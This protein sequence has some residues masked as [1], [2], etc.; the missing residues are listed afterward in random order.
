MG[1]VF[2]SDM[3]D[4][5]QATLEKIIDDTTDE[6]SAEYKLWMD[7]SSMDS[8]F[9]DDQEYGGPGLVAEVAEG[10]S[11][12]EGMI[13]RGA[14]TRYL[15]RKFGLRLNITEEL[16]EDKKYPQA[17]KAAKRLT[18]AMWKTVDVD[19]HLKLCRGFS[20]SYPIGD[21]Q[22]VWSASHTLPGG[23]GTFSN[24]MAVPLS[25]SRI[26]L[27]TATTAIKKMVGHD[28]LTQGYA[29]KAILCPVDQWAVWKGI[30]G[31]EKVPESNFNE[32]NVVRDLNLK[33][34]AL[35]FWDTTATNWALLTDADDGFRFLWRRRPKSNTW[36]ENSN[37]VM[38][39]SISA[40]WDC[41]ISDPRAT[42]GVNA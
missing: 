40:R 3:F 35:K 25:P 20:T 37:E 14:S 9:I 38:C 33:L 23:V 2:R 32:I 12:P 8:A 30:L 31:S 4:I 22:P 27:T 28:G 16:M 7:E 21:Q 19:A 11:I 26:A 18:R 5:L 1:T 17:I 29:P 13:N 41:G 36:V 42:Y 15:A 6:K 10:E 39:H 24:L 34:H